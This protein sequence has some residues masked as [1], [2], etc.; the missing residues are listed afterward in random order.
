MPF[1]PY[2]VGP[3]GCLALPLNRFLDI[4][5]FI[6]ANVIIDLEPLIVMTFNL[7]YPVHGYCHTLLI[8]GVLGL[9]WAFAAYPFRRALKAVMNVI[10]LPYSPS[11]A[12]MLIS[13]AT[14][15]CLHVLF[16]AL[17]Y[18]EM[19]PSWP[20][21][22]NPL[23]GHFSHKAVYTFCA[24]CFVPTLLIYIALVVHNRKKTSP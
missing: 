19:N 3:H 1:T 10:R 7:D 20:L 22:G 11:L 15:A 14:G 6:G 24:L 9:L 4:P 17:L 12:K 21:P 2:H 5:V 18:N 8:G 23:Y 16:D 13:G